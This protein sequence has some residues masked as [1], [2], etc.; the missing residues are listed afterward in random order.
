MHDGGY[1]GR[2]PGAFSDYLLHHTRKETT[3]EYFPDVFYVEFYRVLYVPS[4]LLENLIH[5]FDKG[6]LV[7]AR[8]HS[9]CVCYVKLQCQI[10]VG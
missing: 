2:K 1:N 7:Q 8:D 3:A 10:S 6:P 4:E 9:A 5:I